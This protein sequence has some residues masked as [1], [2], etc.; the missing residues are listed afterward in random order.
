MFPPGKE[1]PGRLSGT[2]L[3]VVV[4]WGLPVLSDYL[5]YI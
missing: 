3:G 5:L 2:G 1:K 4:S